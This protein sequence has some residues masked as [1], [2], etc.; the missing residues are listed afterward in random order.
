[1]LNLKSKILIKPEDIKPSSDKF[2]VIGVFNPGAVRIKNGK[3]ILYV[4]VMEK[5]KKMQDARYFYSPRMIG[6]K[7]FRIKLDKFKKKNV[8]S[9]SEWDFSFENGTKRLTFISHLR[10]VFLDKSG[11]KILKM[12]KKPG[13]FGIARDGELGV[14]DARIT[15]IDGKYYMTYVGLSRNEGVSTYLAVSENALNWERKGIIFGEP[16]KDVVLFPEKIKGKYVA[17]DRPEGGFNFKNPRIWIAYSDDLIHWGELDGM[18]FLMK[19]KKFRKSGAGPSPIKTAKGWLF[20]FHV[21]S[22]EKPKKTFISDIKKM[23]G[24]HIEHG[25]DV[26][27]VWVALLD[28]NNPKKIIAKSHSPIFYPYNTK[29]KSSEGKKVIF[30]TG[31]VEDLGKKSFLIYSGEA[32][33]Y[34]SVIKIKK[35]EIFNILKDIK[36]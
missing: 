13:F 33:S 31:I 20:I 18:D 28:K 8:V 5:L 10:R 29:Q 27:G 14:E 1:M 11:L 25:E 9:D 32:D 24:M 34:T 36:D 2:E 19:G 4:R 6:K 3:I 23:L 26:Y 16:D 17:F 7:D 12:E 22:V 30:P 21:V 35:K 15:K